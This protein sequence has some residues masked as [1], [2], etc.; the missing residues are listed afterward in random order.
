MTP[1]IEDEVTPAVR[2]F[3]LAL[4]RCHVSS[5]KNLTIERTFDPAYTYLL[6]YG[7]AINGGLSEH[8]N[9]S[10][11]YFTNPACITKFVED[12]SM[13]WPFG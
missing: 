10:N 11:I 7:I 4:T 5:I 6:E 1:Y 2:I 12:E 8:S 13:G 9:N 3:L